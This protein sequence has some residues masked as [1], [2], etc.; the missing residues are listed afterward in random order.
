MTSELPDSTAR[1]SLCAALGSVTP[2]R[3]GRHLGTANAV[4]SLLDAAWH[5]RKRGD[6]RAMR[7]LALDA[8]GLTRIWRKQ[9]HIQMDL[10]L[11][12]NAAG[13]PQP[14]CDSSKPETL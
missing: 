1:P 2:S 5:C 10:P 13:E 4:V 11:S 3:R 9:C 7:G 12:P 14:T 8:M 6:R